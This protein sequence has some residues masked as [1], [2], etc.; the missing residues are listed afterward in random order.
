MK[1]RNMKIAVKLSVGFGLILG[2][3]CLFLA[4]TQYSLVQIEKQSLQI[5]NESLPFAL[6]AEQMAFDAVQVQQFLTDVGA[7]HEPAAYTEAEASAKSFYDG[8]ARFEQ[9]F[10]RENDKQSL[11]KTAELKEE[12]ARFYEQG[13]KMA[14]AYVTGGLE[15]GNAVMRDFDDASKSMTAK[16]SAFRELN[17]REANELTTDAVQKMK[18]VKLILLALGI[19][20]LIFGIIISIIISRSITAPLGETVAVINKIAEGDLTHKLVRD[21]SDELGMLA[22]AVNKMV[23]DMNAVLGSVMQ[24]A[25]NVASA[26]VQMHATSEQIATGMAEVAGQ[27]GTVAVAGEEMAATSN[28]IARNC[29]MAAESAA[30]AGALVHKSS[31]TIQRT[32]QGIQRISGQVN[33]SAECVANLGKRSEQIGEII[34]TIEEIADQTNLLALNAAI[35]AAR[36]GEQGRG[37]AVV[38]DEVRALATRTAKATRD[39]GELIASIQQGI[40]DA[41]SGMQAGVEEAARGTEE[42]AYSGSA[43]DEILEAVSTISAQVSQIATA[44]EEQTATTS[45]VSTNI[46]QITLVVEETSKG[47]HESAAAARQL[48]QVA[49][50]LQTQVQRFRLAV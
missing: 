16:I 21:S 1:F 30:G 5:K 8:A 7:T 41:M 14:N 12:F 26:S 19:A 18:T 33:E 4:I 37:F 22:S 27:T 40:K 23:S 17:V 2:I 45:E 47:I 43:V 49:E 13:K 11:Q 50:S 36:A 10:T 25:R 39:I 31:A 32:V 6:L 20:G 24:A 34:G 29:T 44:A 9:M 42:A 38:A 28:D 15:G 35:E 46:Q 3:I 48:A